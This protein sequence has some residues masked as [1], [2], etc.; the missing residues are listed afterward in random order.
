MG[1]PR[2]AR[3]DVVLHLGKKAGKVKEGK[4]LYSIFLK[5]P[6]ILFMVPVK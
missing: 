4:Y 6:G 3:I 1:E 5:V 2:M